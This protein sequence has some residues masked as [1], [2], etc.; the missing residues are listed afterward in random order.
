MTEAGAFR[1]GSLSGY[2]TSEAFEI[3][4]LRLSDLSKISI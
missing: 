2:N 4:R 3:I 1:W